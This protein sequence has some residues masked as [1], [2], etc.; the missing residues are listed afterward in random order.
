MKSAGRE[1]SLKNSLHSGPPAR[2][3]RYVS[4]REYQ[5]V[6]LLTTVDKNIIG[7]PKYEM[8]IDIQFKC[9]FF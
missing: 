4:Q 2:A 7:A 5:L 1:T 9:S 3:M 6:L 8:I